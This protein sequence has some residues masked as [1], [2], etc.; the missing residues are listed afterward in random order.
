MY[1]T[2]ER[3]DMLQEAYDSLE[4]SIALIS[5]ALRGTSLNSHAN[6]YIIPH[7]RGWLDGERYNMGIT[8]YQESLLRDGEEEDEDA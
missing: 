8:R 5:D 1:N 7:L 3:I 2:D 4:K 6:S